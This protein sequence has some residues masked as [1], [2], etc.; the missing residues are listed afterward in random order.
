MHEPY[1]CLLVTALAVPTIDCIY[2][3][4]AAGVCQAD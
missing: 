1:L 2:F 3:L 4:S